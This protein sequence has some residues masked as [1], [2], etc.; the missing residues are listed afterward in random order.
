MKRLSDTSYSVDAASFLRT[1]TVDEEFELE[2]FQPAPVEEDVMILTA[3]EEI[4][5]DASTLFLSRRPPSE[6]LR[7]QL[8]HLFLRL[9][10]ASS[11]A[12]SHD[13]SAFARSMSS[14]SSSSPISDEMKLLEWRMSTSSGSVPIAAILE[15]CPGVCVCV[16]VC[17]SVS[18]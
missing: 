5:L 2:S 7:V 1:P 14:G 16:C 4:S 9:S 15:S 13:Q 12:R 11:L 3:E 10:A 17:V 8:E 18:V 6:E